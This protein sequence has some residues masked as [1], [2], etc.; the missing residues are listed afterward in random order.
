LLTFFALR[1]R[2][3]HSR[4]LKDEVS[5]NGKEEEKGIF[6]FFSFCF[7]T[8]VPGRCVTHGSGVDPCG[9]VSGDIR[10]ETVELLQK[11]EKN[12]WLLGK[13]FERG[14]PDASGRE[15]G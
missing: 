5:S 6:F 9:H 7:W 12:P 10:L 1:I 15:E 11:K 3:K 14:F 2:L 13:M 4:W 8:G